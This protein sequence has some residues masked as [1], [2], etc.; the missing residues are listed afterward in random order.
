MIEPVGLAIIGLGNWGRNHVRTLASLPDCRVHYLYDK[1]PE[2]VQTQL[3]TYPHLR[4]ARSLEEIWNDPRVEAVVIATTAATHGELAE[5]ALLAGKDVFV[6]KPMTLSVEQ[7]ERL[8]ELAERDARIFQVGHLLLH[9][10]AVQYLKRLIADGELGDVQYV[11]SQRLN[12]GVVR[13]DE[14]SLWSLAPHD[15]SLIDYLMEASPVAVRATGGCYL[16]T[17]IED[18]IFLNLTYPRGRIAHIHVSWLDPHK[19]RR[20]TIVGS[21]KMAVFDDMQTTEK[22]RIYDK[23]VQRLEYENYG[24][25][26]S[27]RTGDILIPSIPNTEP[28]KAQAQA[29]IEAVCTRRPPLADGRHGLAIIRTLNEATRQ[30]QSS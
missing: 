24:E 17:G 3:R 10:P 30:L 21:R 22:V 4:S 28:L 14:N 5:A 8:C 2:A 26:M 13:S 9:H 12:F 19:V 25:L 23:G 27:V 18:V 29:F 15:I 6:E 11:Y 7:G 20:L 1:R 16:Q